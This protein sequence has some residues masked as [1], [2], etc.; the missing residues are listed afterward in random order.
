MKIVS[1]V[2]QN[3]AFSKRLGESRL[4]KSLSTSHPIGIGLWSLDGFAWDW[5]WWQPYLDEWS[6]SDS[7]SFLIGTGNKNSY[8][9]VIFN[10]KHSTE[11]IDYDTYL[12][13]LDEMAK[14]ISDDERPLD[15]FAADL[16]SALTQVDHH[17]AMAIEAQVWWWYPDLS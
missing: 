1:V 16:V 7:L 3:S 8:A 6:N 11:L 9:Y 17:H 13:V 15:L 2:R 12:D 14:C 10:G 4:K 5:R